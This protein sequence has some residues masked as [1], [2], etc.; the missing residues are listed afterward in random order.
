MNQPIALQ[1]F[2]DKK[3]R[4]TLKCSTHYLVRLNADRVVVGILT[5]FDNFMNLVLKDAYQVSSIN[6]SENKKLPEVHN[7]PLG[8]CVIRGQSIVAFDSF[9]KISTS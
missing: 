2:M 1:D 6:S 4:G 3:V 5:G 9:D 7:D 8:S